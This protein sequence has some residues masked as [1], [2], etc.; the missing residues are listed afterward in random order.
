VK[1]IVPVASAV[2]PARVAESMIVPPAVP[3]DWADVV[4][5]VSFSVIA[6]LIS[7]LSRLPMLPPSTSVI[8]M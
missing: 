2:A 1:V 3:L 6:P 8:R 4:I 5:V 7:W